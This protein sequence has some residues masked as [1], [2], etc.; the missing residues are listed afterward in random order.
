MP[1]SWSTEMAMLL[2]PVIL[3]AGLKGA[4][5]LISGSFVALSA[6]RAAEG[7]GWI[8]GRSVCDHCQRPLGFLATTPLVGFAMAGG[9]C[10]A[11][12]GAIGWLPPAAE[13]C[14]LIIW[15]TP[16]SSPMALAAQ[17]VLGLGLL[18]AALFDQR[19]LRIP[20][21]LNALLLVPSAVLA[22]LADRLLLSLGAACLAVLVLGL[23]R[24]QN[25]RRRG[26]DGI[27]GGDIRLIGVLMLALGPSA[28]A[29]M[30]MAAVLSAAAWLRGR[31]RAGDHRLAF[32]PFLAAAS[33]L[34]VII[35]GV[36]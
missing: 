30:L 8:A 23:A 14:G 3:M 33:W 28:G 19:A 17:I 11:C 12:G 9:R 24:A 2:D 29:W 22:M 5:G 25:R 36:L 32:A 18:F 4:L 15:L 27:G 21:G 26:R 16:A 13:L 34:V 31:D 35:G 20:H 1:T 7:R 6:Q 10:G